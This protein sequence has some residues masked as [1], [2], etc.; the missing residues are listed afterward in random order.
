MPLSPN[1]QTTSLDPGGSGETLRVETAS[2]QP[3]L[4]QH[5]WAILNSLTEGLLVVDRHLLV[6]HVN[7]AGLDMTGFPPSEILG[8]PWVRFVRLVKRSMS[9]SFAFLQFRPQTVPKATIELC[10]HLFQ[11]YVQGR[12]SEWWTSLPWAH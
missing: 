11:D 1:S 6:T 5:L 12:L 10:S 4:Q 7:K 9:P 3:I 8:R 2:D